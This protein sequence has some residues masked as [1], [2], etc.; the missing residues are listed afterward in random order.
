MKILACI[1][2]PYDATSWYRAMGVFP[3]LRNNYIPDLDIEV[4]GGRKYSWAELLQFDVM[5]MQRPA[6][7]DWLKLAEYMKGM[8]KK[9][10][11]DHDDNLFQLPVYNRVVDEYTPEIKQGMIT[12]MRIA[13]VITVSTPALKTLFESFGIKNRI[14]VIPNALNDDVMR[15]ATQWNVVTGLEQYVWRG[16]E[17]HQGD[18]V[19]FGD[20]LMDAMQERK[21]AFWTFMGYNPWLITQ[22]FNMSVCRYAKP[23]DIMVYTSNFAKIRP[24]VL[25]VPLHDD[26]LNQCKSNIAWIEGTAAGAVVIAPDWPEWRKPG[27]LNYNSPGEYRSLLMQVHDEYPDRWKASAEY[28]KNNLL[29]TNV[30]KQRAEILKLWR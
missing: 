12:M 5:F 23:D 28:V 6:R 30:N 27:V 4:Y 3:N 10:W 26:P 22:N 24:Q 9:I 1:P 16:S 18:L 11:I 13:D 25:H 17:T 20:A 8:G 14:E 21:G 19:H 29:L 2:L 15:M 7:P